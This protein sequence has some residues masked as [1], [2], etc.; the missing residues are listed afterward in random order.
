MLKETVL[1]VNSRIIY[2]LY[3]NQDNVLPTRNSIQHYVSLVKTSVKTVITNMSALL[4][5]TS[6]Y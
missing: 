2:Y 5:R 6:V 3:V 4:V 1:N